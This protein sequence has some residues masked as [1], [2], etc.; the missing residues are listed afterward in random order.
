MSAFSVRRRGPAL[1]AGGPSEPTV[2]APV[3]AVDP[4]FA[5]PEIRADSPEVGGNQTTSVLDAAA[6]S[7]AADI[8]DGT[9]TSPSTY[10]SQGAT[11]TDPDYD[12]CGSFAAYHYGQALAETYGDT[13][14]EAA[15]LA[16]QNKVQFGQHLASTRKIKQHFGASQSYDFGQD[17]TVLS[18]QYRSLHADDADFASTVS[19]EEVTAGIPQSSLELAGAIGAGD[20]LLL[21][22]NERSADTSDHIAMVSDT[23]GVEG[24]E[25][26]NFVHTVEGNADGI[27]GD[28]SLDYGDGT[29]ENTYMMVPM[30]DEDGA[31]VGYEAYQFAVVVDGD[32]LTIP[33]L[34]NNQESPYT[35]EV[36]ADTTP[37][38][39]I[40]Q[41]DAMDLA[42]VEQLVDTHQLDGFL[43]VTALD[44]VVD[45]SAGDAE[46]DE[47]LEGE[48]V[49]P[50]A[51]TIEE[52]RENLTTRLVEDALAG[53]PMQWLPQDDQDAIRAWAQENAEAEA[54][55][56]D[57]YYDNAM[58]DIDPMALRYIPEAALDG[59]EQ[60]AV[61]QAEAQYARTNV[62]VDQASEHHL[63]QWGPTA[64]NDPVGTNDKPYGT[65]DC[66]PTSALMAL[67]SLGILDLPDAEGASAAIDAMRDDMMGYDTN[68]SD[69]MSFYY[70]QQ[71][72]EENGGSVVNL[73]EVVEDPNDTSQV[74]AAVDLSL[75]Q[76]YPVI[77]GS[78]DTW[79]A[80]GQDQ[81]DAATGDNYLNSRS[82]GGHYV[83][84]LGMTADGNYLVGDPL[85]ADGAIEVSPDDMTTALDGSFNTMLS[86]RPGEE[87][88]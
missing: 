6:A 29:N 44:E 45:E 40:A 31:V 46:L 53:M 68:A 74:Q 75:E 54:D 50:P 51:A 42:G 37:E 64:S 25:H 69:V 43:D 76:G 35:L 84:I 12:W 82:P 28:G 63:T 67:S 26:L 70:V 78:Y 15:T 4:V 87:Q 66:G 7:A 58:P 34:I 55:R 41:I 22:S 13:D 11:L 71:G 85:V 14:Q 59:M 38:Q 33:D 49:P 56:L 86:V 57:D 80:W 47:S 2:T 30:T 88:G 20:L 23:S 24:N 61:Q 17:E 18:A 81:N 5:D 83:A 21:D 9:A 32:V 36:D 19:G 27:G 10:L 72:I 73:M 8:H 65:S 3:P 77:L 39:I 48:T 60:N 62:T 16:Y 79:E 52:A 1:S